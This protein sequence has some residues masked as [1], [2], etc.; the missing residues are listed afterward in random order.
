MFPNSHLL[1]KLRCIASASKRQFSTIAAAR[2]TATYSTICENQAENHTEAAI[3]HPRDSTDL[4][5]KWGCSENDLMKIFSRQ[6]ALRHAQVA[7][8]LPKLKLLSGLGLTTSDIVK[9]INCRPCFFCSRINHCFDE[10]LDFFQTLFGPQEMMRKTLVRNP[11]LLTYDFRNTIKPVI[12]LYEEMGITGNDL[13][14]M[15]I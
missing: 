15:L 13:I 9:M 3:E 10:L 1:L 8:L 12:A 6:P 14:V 11:S 2:N 4:F 7:P 5:R